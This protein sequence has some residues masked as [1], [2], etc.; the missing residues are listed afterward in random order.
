MHRT[1][2][3]VVLAA[4]VVCHRS[5]AAETVLDARLHHL[6]NGSE[7]EWAD[8]PEKPEAQALTVRFQAAANAGERA[9]RLRQ[10]DVKQTWRV[11][12]NGKALGQL[13]TDENDT[14]IYLPVPVNRLADGENVLRIEA[15]SKVADDVR[16]GEITLDDRP[17]AEVLNE[18]TVEVTVLEHRPPAKP[19]AVPCRITILNRDGALMA[20]GAKSDRRLAVRSGV[21]YT[22][23]GLAR[24]GLPAGEYTVYAGRGFEYGI[25]SVRV[26]L[27]PGD[28][29]RKALTIRR[30]VPTP[31]YAS[32]DTHV[33]T[34]THSGHGDATVEERVVT[35]AGEGL[36][37]P[38]ATDHNKQVS[39]EDAAEAAGVR[40]YF[41]PLVGNEVTTSVG[42]FNIFPAKAGGP[43]PDYRARD[44]S[45]VFAEI[46]DKTKAPVVVLNHPRDKHA[47]FTPF[48][49]ERILAATG[50]DLAGWDLKANAIEVVNSGAQQTDV[51]RP[52]RDWF[53]LLNRG[54]AI[55]P[56]GA[57]DSHDVSRYIVGQ[58]R[59]Y[60]RCKD[61]RPGE[62][63]V[64]EVVKTFREGRVLVS[65]GLLAEIAVNDKYGPGDLVPPGDVKVAVRVLGPSWATADRVTLYANGIQV[66]EAE[67]TDGRKPGV[68]WAG[69]WTLPRPKHDIHL[70]AIATGPGDVGLY[71]PIGKPYQPTGP[72]V[73]KR[74]IGSTGAVWVDADGDGRR[75]SALEYARWIH[76]EAG[77]KWPD[78]VRALAGY[79]EAVAAQAA[80]LLH[81]AGVAVGDREVR[82]AARAAG[83]QVERGFAVFAVSWR[84]SQIARQAKR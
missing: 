34:L 60:V 26:S 67:V 16:V 77:G 10:Q 36:E 3:I 20:V 37:L 41:T 46:A 59:T 75:T 19:V 61:D 70:M 22:A 9:L 83:R 33:H 8:F 13:V 15:A 35:I 27:K 72:G 17:M 66:K 58:G 64:E 74:V 44:W 24:F 76:T 25:D 79:D 18:A 82:D 38:V 21:I 78:V 53:A 32:C 1:A 39:Y 71:W 14:V 63:D 68:K 62:I 81:K 52:Y 49:P 29:A 31:G 30:E 11:L 84:E 50:E 7:R 40:M 57:S 42:H 80:G 51:L 73:R 45:A 12:L 5:G 48:G 47:G 69:E 4:L 2:R 56:L 6:R 55:T 43:L 28:T 65:C 23:D 54:T